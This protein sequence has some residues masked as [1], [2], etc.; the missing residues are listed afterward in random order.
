MTEI[1]E[2]IKHF[3]T[4]NRVSTTEV[5]DCLG[6]CGV[7][8]GIYPIN[9][10][11]YCAGKIRYVYAHDES[12]WTIHEQVRDVQP[13]EIVLM[14]GINVNNRALVGELVTKFVIYYQM[15]SAIVSLG[16][17]RDANDLIKCHFPVWCMG[18]SPV[19]CFNTNVSESEEVKQI[20][21]ERK[22]LYDGA[23]AV[24]DD[25]GVV[26]IPKE[27][28]TESFLKKL[29]Q[30]EQQEDIWFNCID[31]KKWNTFDTVCMKRYL[32]EKENEKI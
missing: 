12:N 22:A 18:V 10:G 3:L 13:G 11:L 9:P 6:K 32:T 31:F 29:E 5:A 28:I 7:L 23:F 25:T 1:E 17:M 19:G 30:I 24:C 21:R 8:E 4:R 27:Q 2:K 20:V 15:A 16:R 26:V 14:D